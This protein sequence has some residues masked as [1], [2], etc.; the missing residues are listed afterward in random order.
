MVLGWVALIAVC[1]A[2]DAYLGMLLIRTFRSEGRTLQLPQQVP[3]RTRRRLSNVVILLALAVIGLVSPQCSARRSSR[4]SLFGLVLAL[5]SAATIGSASAPVSRQVIDDVS[6]LNETP[7]FT[8]L[9]PTEVAEVQAGVLQAAR[10]GRRVSVAGRRHS[11][12]G[13]TFVQ[14]GIVLDMTGFNR[15]LSFDPKARVITVQ[16]GVTWKQIQDYVNP[17][18]LA[19]KVQ[20]SSNIFTVG[21]SLGVN[22]HGRDPNYSSMIQTVRA[23]RC[24][25]PD[26]S[27]VQL[28]R[29]ER[30]ELFSLVIGGYGLF[31]IILDVD[32]ELTDNHV[33]EKTTLVLRYEDYPKL[34]RE[35]VLGRSEVELHYARP[36]IRRKD[37]LKRFTVT[38]YVTTDRRPEGIFQLKEES[39]VERNQAFLALSRKYGWGKDFRWFM[40]ELLVDHAGAH[41]I[42]SRN[43]AMRPE[44]QFL[45]Y[46]SP[47]DTDILQEYF[48]PPRNF[49][50]VIDGMRDILL[51]EHV[52]VLSITVRYVPKDVEAFL[53][54]ARED[55][56]AVV[57]YVNQERSEA[58]KTN[59]KQ[60]TQ[61]LVDLVLGQEGTYYLPYQ[62]YPTQEQIR[63]AYPRLHEFFAKKKLYDPQELFVNEFYSH[64]KT[65]PSE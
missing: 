17:Y 5:S 8:I 51:S 26:G 12:G 23:L 38:S 30:P 3:L 18:G 20:Q 4:F 16:S 60:W 32:L 29:T 31:G 22:A 7:V 36:S 54:Y 10:D 49:I 52:N 2:I 48:F 28:S 58:G 61:K 15:I 9:K 46:M 53:S 27:I 33:L 57:L 34:F 13:Q 63:R 25:G 19:V 50:A 64:Y 37:F 11:Q 47:V 55:V 59:A 35:A 62:L 45:E 21:G 6:R 40:Q 43:N 42:Q 41:T 14:D 65:N 1:S 39:G 44:V 24:V 56:F